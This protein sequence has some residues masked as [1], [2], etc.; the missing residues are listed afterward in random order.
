METEQ[1]TNHMRKLRGL[2]DSKSNRA[3]VNWSGKWL[4]HC[5]EGSDLEASHVLMVRRHDGLG[6]G[7][8]KGGVRLAVFLIDADADTYADLL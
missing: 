7:V 2:D 1:N 4:L 6:K 3:L 8:Y 5:L